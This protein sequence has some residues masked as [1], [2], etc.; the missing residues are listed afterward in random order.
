MLT[1][2]RAKRVN[3]TNKT[4]KRCLV[5]IALCTKPACAQHAA[6]MV[7]AACPRCTAC[8]RHPGGRCSS[9]R[10]VAVASATA[11]SV[12]RPHPQ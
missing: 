12:Q 3:K 5:R 10:V 7:F 2:K 9:I 6:I 8:G 4:E 1:N 11:V